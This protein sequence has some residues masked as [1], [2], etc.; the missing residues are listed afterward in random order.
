MSPGTRR[1]VVTAAVVEAIL[2]LAALI[3]IKRRPATEI[4]GPK[5]AWAT[6]VALISSSGILPICY[7]LLGR[8]RH[9]RPELE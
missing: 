1:L 8:R 3:D 2:K 5:W 7:F 9:S 6:S 4:R